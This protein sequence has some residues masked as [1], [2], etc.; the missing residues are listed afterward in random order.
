M[1]DKL[2]VPESVTNIFNISDSIGAVVVGN[3]IDGKFLVMQ[4]RNIAAQFKFDNQYEIPVPVLAQRVG[5]E[6]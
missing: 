5:N 3:M 2:I 6:L 4:I 1:P